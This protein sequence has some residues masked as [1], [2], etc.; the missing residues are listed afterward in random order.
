MNFLTPA[1]KFFLGLLSFLPK[2]K[3]QDA[4]SNSVLDSSSN[5]EIEK[6]EQPDSDYLGETEEKSEAPII[7]NEKFNT[8]SEIDSTSQTIKSQAVKDSDLEERENFAV[9]ITR[10]PPRPRIEANTSSSQGNN[11]NFRTR[12]IPLSSL[13]LSIRTYN[14]LRAA[15]ITTLD[16][17]REQS[18]EGLLTIKGLEKE[19]LAELVV[20]LKKFDYRFENGKIKSD[21]V[22]NLDSNSPKSQVVIQ[23]SEEKEKS[24]YPEILEV[25]PKEESRNEEMILREIKE[26]FD[27]YCIADETVTDFISKLKKIGNDNKL[28]G[29]LNSCLTYIETSIVDFMRLYGEN[30]DDILKTRIKTTVALIAKKKSESYVRNPKN[31]TLLR[32]TAS[33]C[34]L[35]EATGFHFLLRSLAGE[36]VYE[37]ASTTKPKK[38]S[39]DIVRQKL[40][41]ASRAMLV[42][43]K[44]FINELNNIIQIPE[45]STLIHFIAENGRL[46]CNEDFHKNQKTMQFYSDISKLDLQERLSKIYSLSL[47]PETQEYDY[48]YEA[49]MSGINNPGNG[50]WLELENIGEFL[51]RHAVVLKQP[52]LMPKQST[53]PP[54]VRGA[55]TRFG[56]QEYVANKVNLTFQGQLLGENKRANWKLEKIVELIKIIRDD[57]DQ[58]NEW[59]P[60]ISDVSHFLRTTDIEEYQDLK[61]ESFIAAIRKEGVKLPERQKDD[62]YEF[63]INDKSSEPSQ[64]LLNELIPEEQIQKNPIKTNTNEFVVDEKRADVLKGLDDSVR[65]SLSEIFSEEEE[66]KTIDETTSS[67]NISPLTGNNLNTHAIGNSRIKEICELIRENIVDSEYISKSVLEKYSSLQN[68]MPGFVFDQINEIAIDNAGSLLLEEED[69]EKYY[70]CKDVLN[71]ILDSLQIP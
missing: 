10:T 15:N 33:H 53:L 8:T 28:G 37:I 69:E 45:E 50:Y 2:K 48:H 59:I 56:G 65:K 67:T 34:K 57:K 4:S 13:G 21:A 41:L 24:I 60:T 70:V 66:V 26:A 18:L 58:S 7:T 54:G 64:G 32:A 12:A 42:D 25:I 39:G 3:E 38:Q 63:E 1:T 46:P 14:C 40:G 51:K 11:Y 30:Y 49:I 68:L 19:G 23:K 22:E 71:S 5:N 20:A 16:R 61:I 35:E 52:S 47:Q 6:V 36:K 27:T 44:S 9:P 55:V 17:L 29:Y 62:L 43:K 31:A